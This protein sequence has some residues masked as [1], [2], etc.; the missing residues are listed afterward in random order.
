MHEHRFLQQIIEQVKQFGVVKEVKL[1]VGE[2]A[3]VEADHLEAH[4]AE[5]VPWKVT[6]E[7]EESKILCDCGFAGR[8]RIL[9]RGHDFFLFNCPQCGKKPKVLVGDAVRIIG[10][11]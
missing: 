3:D 6:V 1:A 5:I 9:D 4:L 2:L 8:A 11:A 7:T 10:V